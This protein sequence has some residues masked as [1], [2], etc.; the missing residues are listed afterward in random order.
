MAV[1]VIQ[2]FTFNTTSTAVTSITLTKPSGVVG[3]DLL[4]LLVGNE[5]NSNNTSFAPITGWTKEY[6]FGNATPDTKIGMYWRI[7]DGTEGN[8]ETVSW[9]VT[10]N[11]FGGGWYLRIT[12]ADTTSASP[13]HIL[14]TST[15]SSNA[16]SQAAPS[17]TTT[18]NDCLAIAQHSYDGGD[19]T[20]GVTGIGWPNSFPANQVLYATTGA[21]AWS[22]GW[23]SKD[24]TTAG[25]T[26][27][28]T[29]TSTIS[30]GMVQVQFAIAPGA[31]P[32]G[33][34]MKINIGDVWKEV[35]AAKINIG[36]TWKDISA[37]KQN[38]G[39]T[40]KDV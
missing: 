24:I 1:P 31:A 8:S 35:A 33:L 25:A 7:A 34:T 6:E 27:N 13:I 37:I 19:G 20:R 11:D 38:I 5:D 30:D 21:N 39:D 10:G 15:Q 3:G 18:I 26:G 16:T 29:F 4:V 22:G 36:G 32:T 9:A 12:G 2:S 14:G 28:V 40:W 23:V 17:I